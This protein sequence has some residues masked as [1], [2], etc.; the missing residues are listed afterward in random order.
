[1][2][3]VYAIDAVSQ[4]MHIAGNAYQF[5]RMGIISEFFQNLTGHYCDFC[6]MFLR[7]VRISQGIEDLVAL[8]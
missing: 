7:M 2:C 1:M 6:R 4:I 8:F 5:Y 3:M